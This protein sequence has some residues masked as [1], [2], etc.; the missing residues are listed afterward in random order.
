MIFLRIERKVLIGSGN[1]LPIPHPE[2]AVGDG[3]RLGI[4][5]NHD[6][7]LAEL[8]IQVLEHVEDDERVF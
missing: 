3:G 5:G 2:D 6:D 7:R 4:M 8:L 1:D